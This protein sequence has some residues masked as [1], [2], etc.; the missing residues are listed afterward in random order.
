MAYLTGY[1]SYQRS[2]VISLTKSHVVNWINF[3]NWGAGVDYPPKDVVCKNG[4]YYSVIERNSR[5]D[6]KV[7]NIS[8]IDGSTQNSITLQTID[9][10]NQVLGIGLYNSKLYVAGH[11]SDTNY[12]NIQACWEVAADLSVQSHFAFGSSINNPIVCA[13][14]AEN[15][16]YIYRCALSTTDCTKLNVI[17]KTSESVYFGTMCNKHSS[18]PAYSATRFLSI[19]K[20][21]TNEISIKM[22]NTDLSTTLFSKEILSSGT[23][24]SVLFVDSNFKILYND[25]I[26]FFVDSYAD[27]D[28]AI[29]NGNVVELTP[30]SAS[31]LNSRVSALAEDAS[32]YYICASIKG[33]MESGFVPGDATKYDGFIKLVEK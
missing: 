16:Q 18:D 33:S 10:E 4:D 24:G 9:G 21:T 3:Y 8:K 28:T 6:S 17:S 11:Y 32:Y 13:Q 25:T 20:S 29:K 5:S 30:Y 31:S 19:L 1:S 22:F 14:L 27:S 23:E 2:F 7:Y 26:K 12:N 15:G